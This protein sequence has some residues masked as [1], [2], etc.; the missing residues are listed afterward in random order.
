[1]IEAKKITTHVFVF[2]QVFSW[3]GGIQSYA[4]DLLRAY[5]A[6]AEELAIEGKIYQGEVFLL[7][8]SPPIN[9]SSPYLKFHCFASTSVTWGRSRLAIAL[10]THLWGQLPDH[11][12]CGHIKL[13]PLIQWLTEPLG[14][15][16]TVFTHGKE[17]WYTLP[18]PERKALAGAAEIWSVSRYSA[19]RLA[20]ANQIP[21]ERVQVI[22]CVV[23]PECFSL[24]EKSPELLQNYGLYGHQVLLTVARLWSG[25]IY[26]GVDVTIRALPTIAQA[27]PK[28]KYLVIGRGDDQTRLAALAE[29][30]GVSDRVIFAG[31]VA[32]P[33]LPAHYRLADAYVMPSQEGF[34][35]VYLEA[36]ACG[37][38]VLAGDDDG[39]ADPL[40]DGRLGWQ[41]SHRDVGAVAQAC[42][43]ILQGDDQRCRGEWLRQ[44]IIK[45][46]TPLVFKDKL[47]ERLKEVQEVQ[48]GKRGTG[49]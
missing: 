10:F 16:Y 14:I 15:P 20:I 2:L 39:S 46:F 33:A 4:Q 30:L 41:V 40:Q 8:D 26:K 18:E 23:D 42:M 21:R 22:S 11:V 13:A 24:G 44:E 32:T 48:E 25:D 35:I 43:E 36:M 1:M 31:F 6:M 19:D 5:A 37:I 49:R 34:G 47:K 45:S 3:E 12:F 38:P 17:V 27:F 9:F 29:E 7:R 28:V